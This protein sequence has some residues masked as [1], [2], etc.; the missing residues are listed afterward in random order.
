MGTGA[1]STVYLAKEKE[2]GT[3]YAMKVIRKK[4]LKK[5]KL[6]QSIINEKEVMKR[7]R[8]PFI[9]RFYY[10]F[11]TKAKLYF[12][13]EYVPGGDLS[14]L[15]KRRG[16]LTED[17]TRLYAAEITLALEYLHKN[18]IIYR[19][20][21]ST[22]VMLDEKNHVKLVDFGL[23]RVMANN[24]ASTLCGTM[25]NIAPEVIATTCYT[26]AADWW[27]LVGFL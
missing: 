4:I 24:T 17:L 10:S 15:I 26:A 1:F 6:K 14:R 13:L 16:K 19:D 7:L 9:A 25:T 22:N 23:A 27:T 2:S 20:L 21:K 11:Q 8:H 18:S 5:Q 3:Q 12:I